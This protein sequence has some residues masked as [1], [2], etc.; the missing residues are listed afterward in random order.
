[1]EDNNKD[2]IKD[3]IEDIEF[4]GSIENSDSLRRVTMEEA[5]FVNAYGTVLT[6]CVYTSIYNQNGIGIDIE[7]R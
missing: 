7:I 4:L 6:Y 5:N 3:E 2:N 1:M